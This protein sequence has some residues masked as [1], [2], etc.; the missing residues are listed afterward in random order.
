M[1]VYGHVCIQL[2]K[3]EFKQVRKANKILIGDKIEGEGFLNVEE[4]IRV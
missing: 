4:R 2:S 3:E 1:Y